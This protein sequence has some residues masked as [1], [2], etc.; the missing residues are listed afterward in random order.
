MW[1]SLCGRM[2]SLLLGK[3]LVGEGRVLFSHMVRIVKL[4]FRAAAQFCISISSVREL[5]LLHIFNSWYYQ[6]CE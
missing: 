3:Y 2:S 1:S 4:L 6:A 5:Q